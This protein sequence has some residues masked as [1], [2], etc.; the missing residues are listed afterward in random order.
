MLNLA[1][2]AE[3]RMDMPA[4]ILSVNNL[5]KSYA[6][7][8]VFSGVTFQVMER[9]RVGLVGVNGAGKSTILRIL[10]GI[11]A[12]DTG[13]VVPQTGLRIA[14]QAQEARFER[15]HTLREAALDAFRDV[16]RLSDTMASLEQEMSRASGAQLD[17][18]LERYAD[19]SA[20]F[21][22][23]GGYDIEHR[24]DQVLAGLGF[25]ERDQEVSV[26]QLSGGQRTRLSLARALLA[27]PDL[28][29]LD[30][31][32]NHL[33]LTALAWL[34]GF[35]RSWNR[36]V[37]VVS[38]DRFFLDRVTER[39]LDLSFGRLED[40]RAGYSRYL[41]LRK[42]RVATRKAQ[43]EAQR[44]FIARTEEFI[45]KYKAGQRSREARGRQTRLSR[46]ERLEK[47]REHVG[48]RLG[49]DGGPRSGR[50]VLTTSELT[51]GYPPRAGE[52][53]SQMLV[54]TPELVIERGD[55]VALIGPNGEG[56]TTLLRTIIGEIQP[57]A[58]WLQFGTNVKPAYYAQGHEGLDL[59]Q[60]PL[61]A[62]LSTH[63]MSEEDARSLLGSFLFSGD[64]VFK[65]IS[66]LSGGERSRLALAR[67][68][69]ERANLLVL[70]EPTNHL[71]IAS[72]EALEE[73]LAGFEGTILFVSHDRYFIDRLATRLWVIE[74]GYLRT[75]LGNYSD[76]LHQ[77]E[78]EQARSSWPAEAASERRPDQSSRPG[79]SNRD[80]RRLKQEVAAV[81]RQISCLEQR[82]NELSDH[83]SRATAAQDVEA[84]TRLG[85]EYEESQAELEG[86]YA[87]CEELSARLEAETVAVEL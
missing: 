65:P 7:N 44:E 57:L 22:A 4:T 59:S 15:R 20:R 87:A 23:S 79:G 74:N 3:S 2:F 51:V 25:T 41:E 53:E 56:K 9:E 68:T 47:P 75:Y 28:L 40:Y 49:L 64:H 83:L 36:A 34:E 6:T 1:G 21:D 35:L 71:D 66:A 58:G 37:V 81:E 39:T 69:L 52:P 61:S 42:E 67:L 30:E 70:D 17:A 12:P 78:R 63:P 86:A 60:T 32:T 19:V 33:D 45:R 85:R 26:D 14:Y 62:I 27:G 31:P 10:A 72:R 43:Y 77:L 46:L 8:V 5:G 38:H 50:S 82:L 11:E 24:T 29:L 18:L 84:I 13:S 80:L 48:L 73:V 76:Y 55:R 16:R 54:R